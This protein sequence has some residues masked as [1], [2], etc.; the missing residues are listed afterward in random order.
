MIQSAKWKVTMVS[1][2]QYSYTAVFFIGG[3]CYTVIANENEKLLEIDKKLKGKA[4]YIEQTIQVLK[5]QNNPAFAEIVD[6]LSLVHR[7]TRHSSSVLGDI[8]RHLK[9]P[10]M[11]DYAL[12]AF[13]G[14]FVEIYANRKWALQI[15]KELSD[16]I[17]KLPN[18]TLHT[19]AAFI[20]KLKFTI[21]VLS[22]IST[23]CKDA[24]QEILNKASRDIVKVIL[25][26]CKQYAGM[27][28]FGIDLA[29][30]GIFV[31]CRYVEGTAAINPSEPVRVPFGYHP[32]SK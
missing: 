19:Q 6:L 26:G 1:A 28:D 18:E 9:S 4:S 12:S 7:Q 5:S 14:H 24:L 22:G 3:I 27:F 32:F 30:E 8:Q 25:A 15:Q 20:D 13:V 11:S 21:E 17:D 10:T 16:K 2:K 29:K 23:L 31:P